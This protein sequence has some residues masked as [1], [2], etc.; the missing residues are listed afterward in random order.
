MKHIFTLLL[1]KIYPGRRDYPA[2]PAGAGGY[3]F[4]ATYLLFA[5]YFLIGIF[6]RFPWKAD[7]PYSFS[8]VWNILRQ[9]EWLVP[10]V[11]GD[12]FLEKPPLMFWLGALFAKAWPGTAAYES[13]RLAVVLCISV[14]VGSLLWAAACLHRERQRGRR[15]PLPLMPTRAVWQLSALALLVGT[16]GLAEHVH[17]FTADL[18]QMAGAA[19]A[20]AALAAGIAR[21]A[22]PVE[23]TPLSLPPG[24]VPGNNTAGGAAPVESTPLSLPPGIAF[25]A[26]TGIAFLSKG[27]LVAGIAGLSLMCCLALL[28]AFRRRGGLRFA[29]AAL[30]AA[31]PFALPWPLALYLREPE[32]FMQWFWVNNVGRFAGFTELGGHD[33]PLSNRLLSLMAGGAP[34]SFLLLAGLAGAAVRTVSGRCRRQRLYRLLHRRP[35]YAAVL[36]FLTVG[37]G[38]LISSASMRGIYLLPL[39][40][41]MALAA[42][43]LVVRRHRRGTEFG[44]RL[45][46]WVGIERSGLGRT[47]LQWSTG[48]R[49]AMER[50]APRRTEP[51][52][53]ALCRIINALCVALL[54]LIL[55]TWHQLSRHGEPL[56]LRM[57]WPGVGRVFPQFFM[58]QTHW[59]LQGAAVALV[60]L[61]WRVIRARNEVRLLMSWSAGLAMLWVTAFLLLMPWFDAARSYRT[62]FQALTPLVIQGNC[63]STDGLGESELGLLHYVTGRAGTRIYAGWSGEG[64]GVTFNDSSLRCNLRLVQD[65]LKNPGKNLPPDWREIWRGHRPAD[66]NGFILYRRNGGDIS[67]RDAGSLSDQDAGSIL[68]RDK[69]GMSGRSENDLTRR[70]GSDS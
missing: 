53:A 50:S 13:S 34:L 64:D 32:L 51:R 68:S 67:S 11:A 37:L 38:T 58:L 57:L 49:T 16:L 26:G 17:K 35:A 23:S 52:C 40:P 69:C 48:G 5:A 9:G 15:C 60:V 56:L 63:L 27:L 25:G 24:K 33:N 42:L 45:M 70:N 4:P 20:L 18:G 47:V 62:T 22:V 8:I 66:A 30:L 31:L 65:S 1:R 28:P 36:I 41:A 7:E 55:I 10:Y 19:L 3:F 46:R 12:P 2:I 59:L 29:L 39:Y 61:W 43:P 14:T 21:C 6:G 44:V 54:A